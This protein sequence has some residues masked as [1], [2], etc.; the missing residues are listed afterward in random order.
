MWFRLL[1]VPCQHFLVSS[2]NH[3]Q[4]WTYIDLILK[5]VILGAQSL[6]QAPNEKDELMA[7]M[8]VDGNIG[9]RWLDNETAGKYRP[10]AMESYMDQ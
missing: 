2:L 9:V 8:H 3:E 10:I 6:E 5:Y 7:F 1:H 4:V